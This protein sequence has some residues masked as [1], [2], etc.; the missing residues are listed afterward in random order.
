[1]NRGGRFKLEGGRLGFVLSIIF[2]LLLVL[3]GC[4]KDSKTV[5]KPTPYQLVIPKYFPNG[6]ECH[7]R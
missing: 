1:M 3:Q 7:S 5:Y 4:H 6:S 2:M